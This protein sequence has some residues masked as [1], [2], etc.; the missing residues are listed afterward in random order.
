VTDGDAL[1]AVT[2]DRARA[3]VVV[4]H[5]TDLDDGSRLG[6]PLAT[7]SELIPLG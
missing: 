1:V 5:P 7:T 6:A 4:A 3:L 2:E